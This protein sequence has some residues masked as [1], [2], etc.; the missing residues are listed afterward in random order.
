MPLSAPEPLSGEHD[1]SR[2]SCGK[3][4]MDHWLKH[5]ALRSQAAGGAKTYVTTDKGQ[6]AGYYSLSAGSVSR[7]ETSGRFRRNMPEPIPVVLLGR[8]AVDRQYQK[9]GV[10]RG[11]M[12]DAA[13]RV[14]EAAE[15]VG[16]RGI[17]V[18]ALDDDAKN[19]YTTLG[20]ESSSL[21]T[22]TLFITIQDIRKAVEQ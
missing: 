19:F 1:V 14:M 21:D 18:H 17:L 2:F 11:L 20:F 4:S 9:Q 13:Y 10:A 12:R 15:T 5:I 3:E 7:K 22:H 8:L 6:V 16:V